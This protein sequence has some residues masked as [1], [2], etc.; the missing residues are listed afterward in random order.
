MKSVAEQD[1]RGD[2]AVC[3]M[4][5][6]S[7]AERTGG[8]TPLIDGTVERFLC[9]GRPC[10]PGISQAID[11]ARLSLGKYIANGGNVPSWLPA[12]VLGLLTDSV[13]HEATEPSGE[14]AENSDTPKSD[15]EST[16]RGT[17]ATHACAAS[18]ATR[19]KA[20]A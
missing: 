3:L 5:L 9:S 4:A 16:P 18:T 20:R 10:D 1:L 11:R 19:P 8:L 13:A 14:R 17:P 6:I 7:W 12:S 15:L 2:V